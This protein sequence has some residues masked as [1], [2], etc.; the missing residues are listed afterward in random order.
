MAMPV[1]DPRPTLNRFVT[2]AEQLYTL[3]AV[4]VQ[5]LQ[6]TSQPQVELQALQECLENDPAL[7]AKILRVVNSSLFSLTRSVSDLS[8]ALAMLGTKPLKL[9]VL[10]FS[11]PEKLFIGMGGDILR[12]YWRRTLTKAVAARELS[13]SIW[14]LPGDEAFLAALLQDIGVLVLLQELGE[15]YIKLLDLAYSKALAVGPFEE[16]S[17]GFDHRQLSARLLERWKLPS[18]LVNATAAGAAPQSIAQLPMAERALPQIL[19]LA[20]LLAGLLTENRSDL[21]P[22]LLEDGSRFHHLSHSQLATLVNSLQ[23]RVEELADVLVLELPEGSDYNSV[24]REAQERM[25]AVAAD[26]AGE[27]LNARTADLASDSEA[28]LGEIQTLSAAVRDV[29]RS[30]QM[31]KEHIGKTAPRFA[32]LPPIRSGLPE[33]PVPSGALPPADAI[34]AMS[35]EPAA[36]LAKPPRPRTRTPSAGPAAGAAK[37]G[38]WSPDSSHAAPRVAGPEQ[39]SGPHLGRQHS[40]KPG[41]APADAGGQSNGTQHCS[42]SANV[43]QSD[44]ALLGAL[45][46]MA[47]SCRQSRC[48][49]SLLLLEVDRFSELVLTRG[50]Q[51]AQRIVGLLATFCHGVKPR[52]AVWRQIRD[53]R[54]ALIVPDHDRQA[55]V[56]LGYQLLRD[57]RRLGIG[58]TAV[59]EPTPSV[60]VSIGVAAVSLPPKNFAPQDLVDSSERCLHAVRLSGGNALKSIELS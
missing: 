59:G 23:Q 16:K 17:I 40:A 18:S 15:P 6:L 58:A 39:V 44:P 43:G 5:V 14:E 1:D 51:G 42:P 56:E 10:G 50:P 48:P 22:V 35:H 30:A 12:R 46:T 45:A 37:F 49:L 8:Q 25:S 41:S 26:V 53:D 32:E 60:T 27:L 33:S 29:S 13:Q 57:I 20:E 52:D 38:S 2:K 9:L 31:V 28:L 7:T 36:E 55:S 19:H 11:L 54:F 34:S 4:A 24:L 3:P 47:S 21:L